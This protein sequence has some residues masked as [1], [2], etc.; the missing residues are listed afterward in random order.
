MKKAYIFLSIL[1]VIIALS[2]LILPRIQKDSQIKPE[3]LLAHISDPSRYLTTDQIAELIISQD[4]SLL[5]IDA[6]DSI[7]YQEYHLPGAYLV[8][9]SEV[10]SG[11]YGDLLQQ[12]GKVIVFYSN[13]DLSAE[14]AWVLSKRMGI[15]DIYVMKDGL[16]RWMETI[17]RP[18]KPAETASS[19]EIDLYQFRLGASNYFGGGSNAV[20]SSPAP[21]QPVLLQKKEKKGVKEGGC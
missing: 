5:L 6:R 14:Q 2:L 19:V 16:N 8:P 20:V 7:Q 21:A 18:L 12:D 10:T 9:V 13:S 4:P 17:I 3:E 1:M 15:E 11:K